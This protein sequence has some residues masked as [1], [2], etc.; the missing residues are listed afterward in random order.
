VLGHEIRGPLGVVITLTEMLLARELGQ[1]EREL[2][3]LMRLAGTHALGVADDLVAEA[4][5]AADRLHITGAPFDPVRTVR[6]LAALWAPVAAGGSRRVV[7]DVGADLPA[8]VHS[9][10]GRVRQI[11]FNLV[12]NA[13]RHADGPIE[14]RLRRRGGTV[15]FEVADRGQGRNSARRHGDGL[16]IG[17]WI[18]HRLAEALGG[19]LRI[20]DRRGGGTVGRLTIPSAAA[21]DNGSDLDRTGQDEARRDPQDAVGDRADR[22]GPGRTGATADTVPRVLVVDDSPVSLMLM[23]AMLDSFGLSV[24]TASSGREA[25]EQTAILGPDL[26]VVD[27]ALVGET[28]ADVVALL[29]GSLRERMPAV[30]MVTAESSLPRLPGVSALV[31]KPFSP[32]ELHAAVTAVLAPKPTLAPS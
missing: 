16:G 6:D 3:E 9:D 26:V 8:T 20:T 7:V 25:V 30:V 13:T 17:L 10:E 24:T 5:L 21:S 1:S 18:S 27:W 23:T 31:H 19:R 2:V 22:V 28:G 4:G 14:L 29:A 12:S 15:V 32:R 11:L